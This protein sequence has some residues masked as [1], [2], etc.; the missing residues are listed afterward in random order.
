MLSDGNAVGCACK[1][2]HCSLLLTFLFLS[3]TAQD[4]MKPISR[5][6]L[7]PL[8]MFFTHCDELDSF[9]VKDSGD[10]DLCLLAGSRLLLSACVR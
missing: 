5:I 10:I 9:C 6:L 7:A 4:T 1:R 2:K 8:V 3:Y